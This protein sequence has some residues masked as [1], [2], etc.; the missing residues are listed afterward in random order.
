MAKFLSI[1]YDIPIQCISEDKFALSAEELLRKNPHYFKGLLRDVNAKIG[2]R[3]IVLH[4]G[5]LPQV[6][7]GWRQV[8]NTMVIGVDGC[9]P[10]A[11]D[12][13]L[14]PMVA[15]IG[16]YDIGF[17]KYAVSVSVRSQDSG[18]ITNLDEMMVY[19]LKFFKSK[20]NCL[21][22]NILYFRNCAFNDQVELVKSE[23][24]CL[25]KKAFND[26]GSKLVPKITALAI[27]MDHDIQFNGHFEKATYVDH[28][29][30][31]PDH[32][33]FYLASLVSPKV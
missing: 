30:T 23:E 16:S 7:A 27:R 9:Q 17:T 18:P 11:D 28:T 8:P 19:L 21:P 20:N 33:E 24:L 29:I 2:G 4:N 14:S 5:Q 22:A 15:V 6:F 31:S 1:D 26:I 13:L 32:E 12:N 3:S 10:S 25:I